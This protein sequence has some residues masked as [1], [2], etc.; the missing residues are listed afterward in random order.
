MSHKILITIADELK[1]LIEEY[2]RCNPYDKLHFSDIASKAIYEK[3]IGAGV[4]LQNNK[5]KK[6][7]VDEKPM[8]ID[9]KELLAIEKPVLFSILSCPVCGKDFEQTKSTKQYC[10]K[11][12]ATKAGRWKKSGRLKA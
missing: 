9:K 2:D 8:Q 4:S 3:I 1:A 6:L 5:Q 10:S 11:N 12:C 7:Q